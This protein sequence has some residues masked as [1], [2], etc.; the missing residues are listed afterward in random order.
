MVL[1]RFLINFVRFKEKNFGVPHF[2][3][4]FVPAGLENLA[5]S[6]QKSYV[7]TFNFIFLA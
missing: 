3:L 6:T 4:N 1:G 7:F 5:K 2:R